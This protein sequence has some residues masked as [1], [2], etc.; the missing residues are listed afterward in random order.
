[1]CECFIL[2]EEH[3][4]TQH[5]INYGVDGEVV[6]ERSIEDDDTNQQQGNF[7]R[8]ITFTYM[9]ALLS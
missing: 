9:Y 3:E 4:N 5:R 8:F 7:V 6:N 1:M 2:G